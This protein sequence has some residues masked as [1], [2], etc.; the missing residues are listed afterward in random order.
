MTAKEFRREVGREIRRVRKLQ[1]EHWVNE[2]RYYLR[3]LRVTYDILGIGVEEIRIIQSN[4]KLWEETKI[5]LKGIVDWCEFLL[6]IQPRE[7]QNR[8]NVDVDFTALGQNKSLEKKV[9]NNV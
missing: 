5:Y 8:K 1:K 7:R 2:R 4:P 3:V 9:E 6:T